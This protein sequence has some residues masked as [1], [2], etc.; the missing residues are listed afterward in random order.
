MRTM[1]YSLWQEKC[2]HLSTQ[3]STKKGFTL[4]EVLVITII[5]GVL[6]TV[7]VPSFFG[8]LQR[9]R[10]NTAQGEIFRAFQQAQIQARQEN[11]SWQVSVQQA[12]VNGETVVQWRSE[13]E[14]DPNPDTFWDNNLTGGWNSLD[15]RITLDVANTTIEAN[16]NSNPTAW[17]VQFDYEGRAMGDEGVYRDNV[18]N[19]RITL[20]AENSNDKR[21]VI[22]STIL[23]S[24]REARDQDCE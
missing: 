12:T 11:T 10:L 2:N 15:S 22:I 3:L 17:R 4:I 8:Y 23:G 16:D 18:D 19:W 5:I 13:D 14:V 21:C 6:A 20:S 9:Q 24:L 7:A 1:V